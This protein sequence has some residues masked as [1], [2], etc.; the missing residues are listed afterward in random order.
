MADSLTISARDGSRRGLRILQLSG[1][2]SLDSV[3]EF[4]RTVRAETA[5]VVILDLKEMTYLDSSGVGAL[6]QQFSEMKKENRH[7][8]LA[9]PQER[10]LAVLQITKILSLFQRANSVEEAEALVK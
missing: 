10:V 5:G 3:P 2:L 9:R 4:L 7:L 1:R 6:V 8:L